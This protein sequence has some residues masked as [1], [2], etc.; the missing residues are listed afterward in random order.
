VRA[1]G[2]RLEGTGTTQ[3][4]TNIDDHTL[5]TAAQVVAAVARHA[6]V[7]G[8]ELVGLAPAAALAGLGV[9]LRNRRTLEDH[10]DF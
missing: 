5:T 4:S 7:A 2:L 3:V 8:A 1:L 6:P 10:I 9:P